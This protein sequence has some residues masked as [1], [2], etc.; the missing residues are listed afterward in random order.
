MR[1]VSSTLLVLG[2]AL[3]GPVPRSS[4]AAPADSLKFDGNWKFVVMAYGEDEFFVISAKSN[5]GKPT[6]EV[7]DAQAMFQDPVSKKGPSIS[8]VQQK[9]DALTL[10][11]KI[12]GEEETFTGTYVKQGARAGQVLG[13]LTFRG[14]VFPARLEKTDSDNVAP[15]PE[16]REFMTKL[17]N[18]AREADPKTKMAHLQALIN[19]NAGQPPA[20]QAYPLLFQTAIES[21][22]KPQELKAIVDKW[23]ATARPYGTTWVG[24][25]WVGILRLLDGKKENAPLMFE[26]ATQAEK[27]ADENAPVDQRAQLTRLMLNSAKATDKTEVASAAEAKLKRIDEQ[28]DEEYHAKVPPFKPEAYAG[29]KDPQNDRVVLM[30][31]FT[32]AQCPPCVAADVAFDALLK[33]YKPTEAL[34]LQYH[35]HIPGPDPLTN[36]DSVARADYYS[37]EVRGTPS[38]MFNGHAE[39]GGGGP[40]SRAKAKYDE[41]R[42]LI[43]AGLDGKKKA[44]ID[45]DVKRSGDEIK[46]KASAKTDKESAKDA[47]LRLRL[48]LVEE[49]IR[50]VGGNKLRFHHHVVRAFPGGPKGKELT[51]GKGD[52]DLT[53][54]L[55]DVRKGLEEYLSD[56]EKKTGFPNALPAIELKDLTVVAFVQDDSDKSVW[57]AVSAPA[58]EAK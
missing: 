51:D 32:G 1:L 29:R 35:L 57:H 58:A 31:L 25:T 9:G 42:Q 48:V 14:G 55:A 24:E 13:T 26:L 46:I 23:L 15:L 43:D 11:I 37:E 16:K 54:N 38:T 47:R 18:A 40:M 45:L 28:L 39:A 19:D 34:F 12:G 53:V 33:T 41:F 2:L 52:T 50:Y 21:K 49:S 30:E 27:D 6:A 8:K 20:Y 22:L 17:S 5:D 56:F 4:Q 36:N 7:K 3:T 44:Q 10:G